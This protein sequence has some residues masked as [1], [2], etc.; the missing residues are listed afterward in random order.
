VYAW[1]RLLDKLNYSEFENN[2]SKILV[3][4]DN[5]WTVSDWAHEFY[6]GRSVINEWNQIGV[7][8]TTDS[9]EP[10][11]A[12]EL[13]FL[14]AHTI[15]YMD[16]A[17][18]VYDRTK[19]M[20]SLLYAPTLHHTPAVTLTR[21]AALLTVGWTDTQFRKFA[22][23]L[24]EWLLYKFDNVCSE[25][26]D[27]IQAKCGILSDARLSKLF[28]GRTV[29]YTQSVFYDN[30]GNKKC[31]CHLGPDVFCTARVHYSEVQERS[32]PLNKT[33]MAQMLLVKKSQPKRGGGAKAT[34]KPRG[35]RRPQRQQAL[36]V[37]AVP[38]NRR[39]RNK[40]RNRNRNRRGLG[41]GRDYTGQSG[42][43]GK[44]GGLSRTHILEEDEYIGEVTVA[45]QPN[46]N[47]VAYHVNI[48]QA[49]TF[50]WGSVIAKNYEKYQ[51]EYCEFYYKK[52]VSQFATNGQVGKVIMSFDSDASDGA[53]TT[54]QQMEDQ[55]PHADCMPS[56]NLS[57]SIPRKMMKGSMVDAHY[58]RPA[59]L[60]GAA[61]IKT[62]DVGNFYIATQGIVNNVSIGEL[63][64]RYRC[65]LSIPILGGTA[66]AAPQNN[67]VAS[68]SATVA[69]NLTTAVAK[70][71]TAPVVN[72][73]GL[74]AVNTNGSI[75]LPVGNYLIDA[76]IRAI[77]TG[78]STV[79]DLQI[80]KNGGGVNQTSR[81]AYTFGTLTT[82]SLHS[83]ASVSSNGT[84]AFTIVSTGTF[85]TGTGVVQGD[86]RIVAI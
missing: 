51:F 25:D 10:R 63:H 20:T 73:N 53:P 23:E 36:V 86:I 72:V 15:F 42:S 19:L 81:L 11:P 57:L 56:E 16:Q 21:T 33:S 26:V 52:E 24:I 47:P 7:T 30:K 82:V 70:T 27:W 75:V 77:Y 45:N 8:T 49:G 78:L 48:G 83:T 80:Q 41:S 61:D 12:C 44:R 66:L 14:S 54:K 37:N 22:R 18:P 60:P 3:G 29:M 58:V 2:T 79:T 5:T 65:K 4:D 34:R 9:L 1:I 13:D 35:P 6:N 39:K 69:E 55:E 46:F 71:V 50:P 40:P 68:F 43:R 62:Y 28:L 32:K 76:D 84:D 31:C 59:G 64:V 74:G 17:V 67:S 38:S 85:S